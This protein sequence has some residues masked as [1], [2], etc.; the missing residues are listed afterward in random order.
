M[1][2]GVAWAWQSKATSIAGVLGYEGMYHKPLVISH[3]QDENAKKM[4]PLKI[5]PRDTQALYRTVS[6]RA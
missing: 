5:S 2:L 4:G 3:A 6:M 1:L